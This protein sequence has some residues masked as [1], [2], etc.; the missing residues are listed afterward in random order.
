MPFIGHAFRNSY[1]YFGAGP[2]LFDT[3]SRIS[4]AIG[5][6]EINRKNLDLTGP[7]ASFSSSKWVWGGAA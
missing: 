5:L 1:V 3:P 7:P 2:A 6:A 4:N